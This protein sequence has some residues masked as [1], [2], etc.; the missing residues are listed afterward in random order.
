MPYDLRQTTPAN[1]G[2]SSDIFEHAEIDDGN[3]AERSEH[4]TFLAIIQTVMLIIQL[5]ALRQRRYL[6]RL[7]RNSNLQ[8][9]I[10]HFTVHG[11]DESDDSDGATLG[12]GR[13]RR[14]LDPDRFPKVPSD[15]GRELMNSGT[16]GSNEQQGAVNVSRS[17][18][19]LARRLL[20]RELARCIYPK[21]KVNHRLLAQVSRSICS[22]Y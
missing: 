22:Y 20:D 11:D 21:Q 6:L 17:Q 19:S 1:Y 12:R 5:A 10:H 14:N 7:I 13:R 9:V 2:T 3:D 18:R 15:E 4:F 16:F 8:D